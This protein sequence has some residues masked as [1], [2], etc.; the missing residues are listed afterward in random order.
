MVRLPRLSVPGVPQ[1]IIQRGNNRQATFFC[2]DDY[3]VY[4]DKLK[5]YGEKYK[6]DVHAFVLMTNHVHLLMTAQTENGISRLMQSL[7]RYYVRYINTTYQR[8]GTLWEGRFKSTLVDSDSYLFK[9]MRYIE[10]NPVR[11]DMVAHPAEY[12]WSSY[13]QNGMGKTIK[14]LHP[15]Q[16]YKQLG[17]NKSER[18]AAY[19]ALFEGHLTDNTMRAIR[20]ATNKSWV[21]GDER[22][23]HQIQQTTNRRVEP[24]SRG[25]DRRSKAYLENR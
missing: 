16:L 23:K 5:L 3:T 19:K 7:G 2:G 11:A 15:H 12:P 22:F 25:G 6:V 14:C 18:V 21:L 1:H 24:E 10:L 13:Q 8:T 9:L 20:D 17:K 4:L